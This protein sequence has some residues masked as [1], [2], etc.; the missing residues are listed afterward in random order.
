MR[1]EG[2]IRSVESAPMQ[3]VF[4]Q[5]QYASIHEKAAVYMRNIIADHPFNDGNKRSGTSVSSIFLMRNGY[6]LSA[7]SRELE[8]FA[9]QVAVEHLEVPVIA[10][11]LKSH[12][13]KV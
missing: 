4:G 7:T 2:R 11:W 13:K 3:E 12:S 1:D 8:D 9:V 5:E 6:V 10:A